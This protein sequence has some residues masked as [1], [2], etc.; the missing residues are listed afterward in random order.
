MPLYEPKTATPLFPAWSTP[1][2][3]M[4]AIFAWRAYTSPTQSVTSIGQGTSLASIPASV[5][6]MVYY[7]S[8]PGQPVRKTFAYGDARPYDFYLPDG[9]TR[10]NA[11]SMSP[12]A[13]QNLVG[14]LWASDAYPT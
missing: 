11:T 7:H 8:E 6:A 1:K 14:N 3:S 12:T 2:G 4:P 5:V 10:T 13:Y 9:S